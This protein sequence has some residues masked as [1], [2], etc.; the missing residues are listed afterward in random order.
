MIICLKKRASCLFGLK[1]ST[2][3]LFLLTLVIPGFCLTAAE[4][5]PRD[6]NHRGLVQNGEFSYYP[7]NRLGNGL[8]REGKLLASESGRLIV[9]ALEIRDTN[10]VVYLYSDPS[11]E[12][13]LGLVND[14]GDGI[15]RLKSVD[16][17][18]YEYTNNDIGY[19]RIFRLLNGSI[20]PVLEKIRTGTG[21]TLSDTHAVFYHIIKSGSTKVT[22]ET[23]EEFETWSFTF[24]LHLT[25]RGQKGVVTLFG[26]DVQDQMASLKLFWKDEHTLG[27]RK[28]T[29]MQ[30]LFD[31]KNYAPKMF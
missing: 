28:S 8:Y 4:L 11:N 1:I 25:K 9:D 7:E 3:A 21:V 17:E 20:V 23:G 10:S 26:M 12:L 31:L 30:M 19:Q 6:E 15:G 18:F 22:T 27:V 13:H 16:A 24:R 14:E 5:H 2:T 29:G